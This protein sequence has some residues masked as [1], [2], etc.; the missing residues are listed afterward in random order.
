MP[1]AP[2]VWILHGERIL[3]LDLA[4]AGERNA[5]ARERSDLAAPRAIAVRAGHVAAIG[6]VAECRRLLGDVDGPT[7]PVVELPGATIMPAFI[8]AHQHLCLAPLDPAG[9]DITL[10]FGAA[11]SELIDRVREFARRTPLA[12]V[13]ATGYDLARMREGR[14]PSREHLDEIAPDRPLLLVAA[15]LHEGIVNSRAL[16][17][18]GIDRDTPDPFGGRIERDRRGRATGRLYEAAFF[19]AEARSRIDLLAELGDAAWE[20]T[21]IDRQQQLLAEGIVRVGDAAVPPEFDARY[22]ALAHAG[23]LD[24]IVH[25]MPIAGPGLHMPLRDAALRAERQLEAMSHARAPLG[26]SKLFLDGG[27]RCAMCMTARELAGGFVRTT[28]SAFRGV[29]I[30]KLRA[31]T[32]G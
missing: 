31:L 19:V 16:E 1:A 14:L 21:V 20:K 17:R 23:R 7:A 5:A 32:A 3:T 4:A 26:A 12:W 27:E 13:R 25:R 8:D 24:V 22:D 10:P 28:A 2:D 6:S 29:P 9:G 30:A 11:F 15:N 18:L